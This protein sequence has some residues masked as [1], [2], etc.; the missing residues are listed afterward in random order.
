MNLVHLTCLLTLLPLQ[1]S[2]GALD[3][4]PPRIARFL[5]LCET[6]RR[7]AILQLEHE[8]RKQRNAPQDQQAPA[9]IAQLEARIR[10]LDSG[11]ELLV[12]AISFPPQVGAIGRLPGDACYIE[13]IISPDEVRVRCHFH[14]PVT[15]VRK[16]RAY[17]ESVV[18]PVDAVIR[19]WRREVAEGQ[20]TRTG[21]LFEVTGREVYATER[22]SARSILILKPFDKKELE[23]YLK[24]LSKPRQSS[25][26]EAPPIF[27]PA[28][29]SP[30]P[31]SPRRPS[32]NTRSNAGVR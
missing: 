5:E 12:P 13:Q 29:A 27:S 25:P 22:G 14:V 11:D 24:G 28:R 30:V 6:T 1:A 26:A 20:D 7:G 8:L 17:R 19:G 4:A 32:Q 16:F 2:S 10:E 15:S 31:G 18:Q 21:E 3:K 23:P 9:K